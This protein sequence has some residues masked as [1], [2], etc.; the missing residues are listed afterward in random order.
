MPYVVLS[1][2]VK[3][4]GNIAAKTK[5]CTVPEPLL[6]LCKTLTSPIVVTLD[7]EVVSP[8]VPA[9]CAV[10]H[11]TAQKEPRINVLLR[12]QP[13]IQVLRPT[14]LDE[15]ATKA[16]TNFDGYNLANTHA[17]NPTLAR[18]CDSYYD[19][20][21]RRFDPAHCR[22]ATADELAPFAPRVFCGRRSPWHQLVLWA[23][24]SLLLA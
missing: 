18:G 24:G 21:D 22:I 2:F 15:L 4:S 16:P 23:N 1:M 8:P 12:K 5:K 13:T 17:N 11:G 20:L 6:E 10:A 14:L 3:Y 19:E 9:G 7:S